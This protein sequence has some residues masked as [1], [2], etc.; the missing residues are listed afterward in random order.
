[1]HKIY[2]PDFYHEQKDYSLTSAQIIVPLILEAFPVTSVVDI[3]C[4]VGTWMSVFLDNGIT[5]IRGFDVSDL[6]DEYYLVEKQRITTGYD[7][8]SG[9]LDLN[10]SAELAICLEVAEHLSESISDNLVNTLVNAAPV[11]IFSAAFPGQTGVNHINE[12]P[13]WYWREKFRGY[14]YTEID[15]LRP[16]IWWDSEVA[17]WYRQNITSYVSLDFLKT[18]QKV[19]ELHKRFKDPNSRYRLTLVSESI[20]K[21]LLFDIQQKKGP[22]TRLMNLLKGSS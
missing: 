7:F 5:D 12:Q 15:F 1:M 6:P 10:V 17:W 4:G 21:N 22:L 11:V 14:G 13:P 3:G 8:S 19:M 16:L 9:S 2:N 18:N 20:L